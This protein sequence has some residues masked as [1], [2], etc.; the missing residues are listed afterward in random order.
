MKNKWLVLTLFCFIFSMVKA[1]DSNYF[2]PTT[3]F[4]FKA[5]T[6]LGTV[7]TVL[8]DESDS[9]SRNGFYIGGFLAFNRSEK[10]SI[11]TEVVYSSTEF[12]LNDRL[13]LLH[14][15]VFVKYNVTDFLG[16]YAGPESQFLLSISNTDTRSSIYKKFILAV[17]TGIQLKV[18]PKLL[19]DARYSLGVSKFID[20][21]Y[22]D[23]K[24]L[25]AIQLGIVYSFDYT[26]F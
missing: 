23:Y 25:N 19:I 1:Q 14:I 5:G 22:N 2:L 24:K 7:K 18:S 3:T 10:V 11:L 26:N 15:P 13:G 21:S 9:N 4:G 16:V 8:N 6:H 20:F 12:E 17:D